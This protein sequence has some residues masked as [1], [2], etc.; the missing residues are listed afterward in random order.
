MAEVDEVLRRPPGAPPSLS[1]EMLGSSSVSGASTTTRR[2][3]ER[4]MRTTSG[5]LDDR[6]TAMMPSTLARS[7]ARASDPC[8]GE[9]NWRA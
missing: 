6:P 2:M 3:P 1:T 9:M 7:T 5:W 4:R 8:S